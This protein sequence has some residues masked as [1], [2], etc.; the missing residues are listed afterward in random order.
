MASRIKAST[1]NRFG[2]APCQK[3]EMD[4]LVD[5]MARRTGLNEQEIREVLEELADTEIYLQCPG[6]ALRTGQL[7]DM[8][9]KD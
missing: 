3:V 9:S 8:L 4:E 7:E 2:A 1:A 5:L 6:S